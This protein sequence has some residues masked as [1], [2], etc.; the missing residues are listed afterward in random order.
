[1]ARAEDVDI[2]MN[3]SKNE[4]AEFPIKKKRSVNF[5]P[6]NRIIKE[7]KKSLR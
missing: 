1:V 7:L 3:E 2:G 5:M 4:S 6:E